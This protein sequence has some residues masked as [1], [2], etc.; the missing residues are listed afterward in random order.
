MS[1][2][3]G[4]ATTQQRVRQANIA[5]ARRAPVCMP[6]CCL[7]LTV[8][9][10]WRA[11]SLSARPSS[12]HGWTGE[13]RWLPSTASAHSIH[14]L[15]A[16]AVEDTPC[17]CCEMSSTFRW[18]RTALPVRTS[19]SDPSGPFWSTSSSCRRRLKRRR[20]CCCCCCSCCCFRGGARAR[21][22]ERPD[23]RAQH[24]ARARQ[25]TKGKSN[26]LTLFKKQTNMH[27]HEHAHAHAHAHTHT[28]TRT[29]TRTH[30]QTH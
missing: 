13:S 10:M 21:E 2:G 3:K 1:R 19:V 23:E 4:V 15:N 17:G 11:C 24:K 16:R 14:V 30:T 29:H 6:T 22:A 25:Q 8:T 9:T 12:V 27:K 28:R 26:R 7:P 20:C 18:K 5:C